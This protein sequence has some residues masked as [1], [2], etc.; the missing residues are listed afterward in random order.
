MLGGFLLL[1]RAMLD[2]LGGFDEGFRLYGEDIDLQYRAMRAGWERWYVPGRGRPPR[3]Q[4]RDRQA[5]ADPPHALALGRH[6]PLRAQAPRAA[7]G[8]V[9]DVVAKYDAIAER[10]S[11]HDYADAERYYAR[12]AQLVVELGPRSTRARQL[13]DL[14][15]G[16]G[17]LGR[18]L[19]ALG[20]DYRG[21]DAQ[22][23][24]GRGRAA[25]ARRPRRR[26]GAFDYEP[27]EPVDAT[28]I[29][30]SL[31]LVPDRRAFLAR[32]RGYTRRKLVFDFDPRAYDARDVARRRCAPPAGERV[33][34]RPFL[35]PQRA[36]CR[37]RCRPPC[38]RSSRCPARASLTRVRFPLLVSASA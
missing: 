30:R 8:A 17:G 9:S 24:H 23:A 32:V 21:V 27:P 25:R 37:G 35:M 7:A 22:R 31:Y 6:R 38:T 28:T 26:R 12:R 36:R 20:I 3:A 11:A 18:H 4:G 29:F 15:C 1:R 34:L 5:L 13:L 14:A 16:D 19:L 10:Y 33:E 2:E